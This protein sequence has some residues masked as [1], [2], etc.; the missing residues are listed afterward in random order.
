MEPQA[1]QSAGN[2]HVILNSIQDLA[3]ARASANLPSPSGR[4][5]ASPHL[6]SP[7]GRRTEDE[8]GVTSSQQ[9]AAI[10][11]VSLNSIQDLA[12]AR[13]RIPDEARNTVHSRLKRAPMGDIGNHHSGTTRK[14]FLRIPP[15]KHVHQPQR[16]EEKPP[17][18]K[19]GIGPGRGVDPSVAVNL[20][21]SAKSAVPHVASTRLQASTR[22]R[23]GVRGGLRPSAVPISSFSFSVPISNRCKSVK[24]VGQNKLQFNLRLS[25]KSAVPVPN[26][27]NQ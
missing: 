5:R 15:N 6:P 27:N 4:T 18:P 23:I 11:N 7:S 10:L 20:R 22:P 12:E 25:A 17:L 2:Q 13:S 3:K 1:T 26:G 24:S 19:L 9:P 21:P 14:T 16:T 8:G